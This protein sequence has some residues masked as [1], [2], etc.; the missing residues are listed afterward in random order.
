MLGLQLD[1]MRA[2]HARHSFH[3]NSADVSWCDFWLVETKCK[4]WR[5][6]RWLVEK[7]FIYFWRMTSQ[8]CL[9]F[10]L[11]SFWSWIF[12]KKFVLQS[13]LQ[14]I[15]MCVS[16]TFSIGLTSKKSRHYCWQ[17]RS[18]KQRTI[19]KFQRRFGYGNTRLFLQNY[20]GRKGYHHRTRS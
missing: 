8:I 20:F 18:D 4:Y 13:T 12:K 3:N 2:A 19:R 1:C 11:V 10:C 6:V 17:G 16:V 5:T 7:S 9:S 14:I 15:Q